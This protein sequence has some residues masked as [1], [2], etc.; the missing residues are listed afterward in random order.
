[1]FS[2][3]WVRLLVFLLAIGL[4]AAAVSCNPKPDGNE[5]GAAHR[6]TVP[7]PAVKQLNPDGLFIAYTYETNGKMETCGCSSKQLGGLARRGTLIDQYR[8]GYDR[9]LLLLDGG[10]IVPD[11]SEFSRFKS[12]IILRMMNKM[13]YSAMH[14]GF[15]EFNFEMPE[16][17]KWADNASFPL[18]NSNVL[19]TGDFPNLIREK[20]LAD[21]GSTNI[22]A[23]LEAT[24]FYRMVTGK[25]AATKY[26]WSASPVV[27]VT[28][29]NIRIGILSATEPEWIEGL[30][31]K[32]LTPLPIRDTFKHLLARFHDKADLWVAMV[33]ANNITVEQLMKSLPEIKI[34]LSGNPRKGESMITHSK[35]DAGQYWQNIFM[36][37]KYLGIT[38]VDKK[39]G[40]FFI[41][42]E[43]IGIED[44]IAQRNDL[45]LIMVNEYRPKLE[46]IFK[47]QTQPI[48]RE[49]VPATSCNKCHPEEFE[50]WRASKHHEAL[51]TLIGKKQN[52]NPDCVSCHVEYDSVNEAQLTL[53][54]TMCH[55][56][57]WEKHIDEAEAGGAVTP[58][59]ETIDKQYCTKCHDPENSNKF[60]SD[61]RHYFETIKHW[62]GPTVPGEAQVTGG[63]TKG[64]H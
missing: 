42:Q 45:Q 39:A 8:D 64:E 40:E 26:M 52:W 57:S 7:S 15:Y 10:K 28:K 54:C 22:T 3:T 34:W 23:E 9:H 5:D 29:G 11:N 46:Q 20:P 53:Q 17:A 43:E 24:D 63:S 51:P 49:F 44:T 13:G 21:I 12:D 32:Y 4:A 31:W 6:N 14:I 37:G 62:D 27:F 59:G 30:G 48:G 19:Y 16:L 1:L 56:N 36:E 35:T 61:Y 58:L 41:S 18:M 60:D 50:A 33:E 55:Y 2:S 38:S 25:E 47:N